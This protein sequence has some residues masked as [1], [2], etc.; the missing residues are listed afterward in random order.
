MNVYAPNTRAPTFVME[1]LLK[2][3]AYITPHTIIVGDLNT[4]LLSMNRSGKLKLNR[5]TVKL[6]EV[7]DQMDLIDI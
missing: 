6:T 7:L 3:K 5:V 2:L 1:T 4:P